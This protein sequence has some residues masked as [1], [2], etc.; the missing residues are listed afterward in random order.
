MTD[1]QIREGS[2]AEIVLLSQ[3][4]PEFHPPYPTEEYR[5]RLSNRFHLILIAEVAGEPAGFKVGY[6]RK[7][8]FYSW[9]GGVVPGFR[10]KGIAKALAHEQE[11]QISGQGYTSIWCKTRN[12]HKGMLIFTLKNGFDIIDFEPKAERK[13][14]RIILHKNLTNDKP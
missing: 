11:K 14:H 3:K 9:M 1:L 2:I 8:S 7:G 5:Q 12:S 13:A 10:Q 6:E 4:I